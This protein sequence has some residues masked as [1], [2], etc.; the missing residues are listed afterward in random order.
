[1]ERKGTQRKV[2]ERKENGKEKGNERND[3]KTI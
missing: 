2:K 3:K 1:M